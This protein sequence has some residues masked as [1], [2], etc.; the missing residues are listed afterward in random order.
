[1][2]LFLR[3]LF[4]LFAVALLDAAPAT[5]C[6][7]SSGCGMIT[8]GL[9]TDVKALMVKAAGEGRRPIS[10]IRTQ[11]CQDRLRRCYERCGQ[12]GRAA[13]KSAHS[14]GRACDYSA[15]HR[16]PLRNLRGRMGLHSIQDLLHGRG[17]GGGLHVYTT[18]FTR[19]PQKQQEASRPKPQGKQP[20]EQVPVPGEN[21]RPVPQVSQG[22]GGGGAP[23]PGRQ[24]AD[25]HGR[26][27]TLPNGKYRCPSG[28]QSICGSTRAYPW[29]QQWV[30]SGKTPGCY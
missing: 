22:S 18:R 2:K 13:R 28:M 20:K 3:C 21:T 14:D 7:C 15:S 1:M 6:G 30:S 27:N 12:H 11:A 16:S 9:S 23:L 5:A 4:V 25:V 19:S 17:H 26:Y 29:C 24:P 10:C 8:D